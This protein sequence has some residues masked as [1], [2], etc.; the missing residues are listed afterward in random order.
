MT[1]PYGNPFLSAPD[2]VGAGTLVS[3][4]GGDGHIDHVVGFVL[5]RIVV[6]P[7]T[8]VTS[9]SLPPGL[10]TF[11]LAELVSWACWQAGVTPRPPERADLLHAHCHRH[12]TNLL[13]VATGMR[14]KGALLFGQGVVGLSLGV[15]RRVVVHDLTAGVVIDEQRIRRWD[16]A[17]LIPG[18]RGYR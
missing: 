16:E 8:P 13:D 11:D 6:R 3:G 18:A 17:A 12:R 15:R 10:R 1:S 9:L 2:L 4:G 5:P 14:V 7:E